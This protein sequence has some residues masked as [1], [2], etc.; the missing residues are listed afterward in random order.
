MM[1]RQSSLTLRIG[2]VLLPWLMGCGGSPS[3][4]QSAIHHPP[5]TIASAG[6]SSALLGG[7]PIEAFGQ[8]IVQLKGRLEL[9]VDLAGTAVTDSDL[10]QFDFPAGVTEIDLGRTAVT[11]RGVAALVQLP[12][13]EVLGLQGTTVSEGCLESLRKMPALCEVHLSSTQVTPQR[14]LALLPVLA[15]RAQAR[16]QR[17]IEAL[18][19]AAQ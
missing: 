9:R 14:Q 3:H 12:N 4:Q 16:A 7:G 18:R 17:K 11:D 6:D 15:P 10:E 8:R 13:L 2:M 19:Q 5:S 1:A